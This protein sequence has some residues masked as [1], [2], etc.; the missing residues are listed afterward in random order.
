MLSGRPYRVLDRPDSAAFTC[1]AGLSGFCVYFC[2]YS[3]RKPFTAAT[4]DHVPGWHMA[5][6]YKIALVIAHV[7]GYAL[8][9]LIGVKV[10]A[11][12]ASHG[13]APGR[14]SA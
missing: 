6:D 13:V 5:L 14:S 9:K 1:I 2:T 8:S 11:E 3:F 4:F 10:I 12:I 7:A